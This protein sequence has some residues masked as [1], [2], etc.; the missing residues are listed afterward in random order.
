MKTHLFREKSM[1]TARLRELSLAQA[2]FH[3]RCNFSSSHRIKD[4]FS[5]LP[6]RPTN[7]MLA[8]L[9]MLHLFPVS[10]FEMLSMV[11]SDFSERGCSHLPRSVIPENVSMF[12]NRGA[13]QSIIV[14][15][16][17]KEKEKKKKS[18][19]R[20]RCFGRVYPSQTE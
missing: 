11:F 12:G 5:P 20:E 1:L 17:K 7:I 4:F 9:I 14:R 3:S 18:P 6:P 10:I 13:L 2:S 19:F 15:E 16:R 8:H